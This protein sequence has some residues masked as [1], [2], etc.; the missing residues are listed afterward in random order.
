[1]AAHLRNFDA[2]STTAVSPAGIAA[3]VEWI[4]RGNPSAAHRGAA[5]CRALLDE[6]RALVARACGA[7]NGELPGQERNFRA[8]RVIITSGASESNSAL[9]RG[10]V[11]A[12]RYRKHRMPHLIVG[13]VEHKCVVRCVERLVEV[14]Q[15]DVTWLAPDERG[16]YA[17]ADVRAAARANTALLVAMAANNETGA[18]N[19]V[20]AFGRVAAELRI[21]FHCDAAQALGKAPFLPLEWGVSSFAVSAH[22]CAG[23][24]GV[25]ALALRQDFLEGYGWAGVIAGSQNRG[26]RGGTENVAGVAGAIVGLRETMTDLER[27]VQHL[28]RC[29][30]ALLEALAKRAPVISYP[31][32]RQ[33]RAAGERVKGRR[34]VVLTPGLPLPS[35]AAGASGPTIRWSAGAD[36]LALPNTLLVALVHPGRRVCNIKMRAWLEEQ[37]YAVS[38]GSACNTSSPEASHVVRAMGADDELVRGVLRISLPHGVEKAD[39]AALGKLLLKIPAE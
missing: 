22:K 38:I 5:E 33:E 27:R 25:G 2:N 26:L 18:V 13:A 39:C 16:R 9:I 1:M 8:F 7:V 30:Q 11:E 15:A 20:A 3:V 34:F 23:P 17:P 36:A 29:R 24:K 21:P 31:M 28:R 12:Y 6:Y 19:D 35:I 10:V 14:G 37:G 4:N 32:W